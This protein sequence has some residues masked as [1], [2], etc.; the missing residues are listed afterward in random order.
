[1]PSDGEKTPLEDLK[2]KL[3]SFFGT[4]DSQKKKDDLARMV[5]QQEVVQGDVLRKMLGKTSAELGSAR[6]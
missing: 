2:D 6:K 5:S 4:Q 3:R 1:M